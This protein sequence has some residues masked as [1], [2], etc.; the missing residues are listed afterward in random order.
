MITTKIVYCEYKYH[1]LCQKLFFKRGIFWVGSP[2]PVRP[3][4]LGFENEKSFKYI[5]F[6]V[7]NHEYP[8][9]QKN[10]SWDC[11]NDKDDNY[12]YFKDYFK[13]EFREDK[14]KRILNG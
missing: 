8:K 13:Y 3:E 5:M 2:Y 9:D 1:R 10:L 11:G 6:C 12:I 14:L 4:I 7:N